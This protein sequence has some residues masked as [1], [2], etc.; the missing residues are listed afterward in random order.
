MPPG[1]FRTALRYQIND[2]LPVDLST[3]ELDYHLLGESQRKD[4]H[5]GASSSTASSSSPPTRDAVTAEATVARKARLEPVAADSA[6]FALIRAACGGP[7]P[8]TTR[9]PTP[10]PTSAPTSSPSWSTRAA[11]R[12]SSAR[13]P[14]SAA[15]PPPWRVAERLQHRAGRGRAASSARPASTAR[16]R[17]SRRSPSRRVFGDQAADAP[18][19]R[20]R[21]SA[22]T[23]EAL[24]P[25]ATTVIGEIR[26]SLDYFQASDP[27]APIQTLTITGRTVALDGLLERIAT[28]IPLPVRVMDPL[29]GLPASKS[30]TRH[31]E[32]DTRFAVAVGLAMGVASEQQRAAR[33]PR[34]RRRRRPR[35]RSGRW[36]CGRKKGADLADDEV[37]HPPFVPTLPRV[38]LLPAAVRQSLAMRKV[39]RALVAVVVLLVVAV[40]GVW[41]LQGV[42]H[43]RRRATPR[44]RPG[45]GRPAAGA[46]GGPGPDH[47]PGDRAGE[48]EGP[49]RRHP[50]RPAPVGRR[51]RPPRG[52]RAGRLGRRRH[53]LLQ[54]RQSP[55][56][57]SRRPAAP[58]TPAPTPIRSARRPPSA[59][60]PSTPPRRNRQEVS[61][62]LEV[63]EADPLFVGPYVTSTAL[64][65]ADE[66]GTPGVTFSGTAGVSLDGLE[67]ALTA[68][69]IEA[70]VNPPQPEATDAR[71]RSPSDG[72]P[73]PDRDAPQRRR[74]SWRS[75]P[76]AWFLRPRPPALGGGRDGRPGR[77]GGDGQPPAAQPGQPGPRRRWRRHPRPPPRRRPC[78]PPC[79]G[80][81][82]C[83]PCCGRSPRPRRRPASTRRPS[84]SSAP[85]SRPRPASPREGASGVSLA[86]MDIG[87]TVSGNPA[88]PPR[89]PRQPA[90]PRPR[91]PHHGHSGLRGG[92]ER[93]GGGRVA[94]DAGHDV[95]AAVRA[96]RPRGHGGA[97]DR[98]GRRGGS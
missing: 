1:D 68:E 26:N 65:A 71:R 69:Q 60:S 19:R 14:T 92:P 62:L 12:G 90:G 88:E 66:A 96:A 82:S 6:A 74:R 58:S 20:T 47:R 73:R 22:S 34:A 51:D 59:A 86:E 54:R 45:R 77:A 55:T 87:I 10:S 15:T 7:L 70:I 61:R 8:S 41:Y 98:G 37:E 42:A 91:A 28:Q 4:D 2:A 81:P 84:R 17:S 38:N 85:P 36:S 64:T 78:S 50:R 63:L 95:R 97:A 52:R 48:P 27:A 31:L 94:D 57:A 29:A 16:P 44:R 35:S 40:G 76:L 11:S 80:P 67:T 5:G 18:R 21:A 9:R 93:P 32:P 13:S 24:N 30:V 56:R 79:P 83:R 23:V 33:P 72:Q 89:L 46:G 39:R 53:R 43:R 49:G 25:W 75:P 3:V